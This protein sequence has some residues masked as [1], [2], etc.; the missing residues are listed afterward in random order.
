MKKEIYKLLAAVFT[1]S[2]LYSCAPDIEITSTF[3]WSEF[4][5]EDGITIYGFGNGLL[6]GIMIPFE[7]VGAFFNWL[8]DL[9]WN[10]GMW[11]DVNNGIRYWLGYIIGGGLWIIL[12]TC[13]VPKNKEI[14]IGKKEKTFLFWK[15]YENEYKEIPLPKSIIIRN[16]IVLSSFIWLTFLAAILFNTVLKPE[17]PQ[18]NRTQVMNVLSN[19]S[20]KDGAYYYMQRREDYDFF[21]E[22]YCDSI[23]PVILEG[24]FSDLKNVYDIVKGTPAGD[25]LG[26]WYQE[27]KEVFK[28]EMF[29]KLDSLT[30]ESKKF[31]KSEMPSYLSLVIDSILEEDTHKIVEGYCGGVMNYRKLNLLF[32]RDKNFARFDDYTKKVLKDSNYESCLTGYCNAYIASITN[33]QNA[34]LYEI[35]DKKIS[36]SKTYYPSFTISDDVSGLQKQLELLTDK[37]CDEVVV[38]IFKDGVVPLVFLFATGEAAAIIEGIYTAG[39]LA[40][41]AAKVYNDIKNNRL[42]F[43]EKLELYLAQHLQSRLEAIYPLLEASAFKT[44]DAHNIAVKQEIEKVL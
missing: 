21:D 42:S 41:D 5:Y 27:G 30:L 15:H 44:I 31:F 40:Y 39:T 22:L 25:I 1:V 34:Y 29:N 28:E 23:V 33:M 12:I 24:N 16:I 19:K 17:A 35:S 7:L 26:P 11:A 38:D 2:L 36:A 3:N 4:K 18:L 20:L 6:H 10:I 37:E 43:N 13:L 14:L 32:E 8:F 9:G